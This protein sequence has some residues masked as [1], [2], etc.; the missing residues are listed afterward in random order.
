MHLVLQFSFQGP[1]SEAPTKGAGGEGYG[2]AVGRSQ[3]VLPGKDEDVR[4]GGGRVHAQGQGQDLQGPERHRRGP[5]GLNEKNDG[6]NV[7]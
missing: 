3:A 5:E 1:E 6:M 7:K 4:F 2:Q